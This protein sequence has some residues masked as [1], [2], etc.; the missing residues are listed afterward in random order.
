ME[1]TLM[2]GTEPVQVRKEK[3]VLDIFKCKDCR[4]RKVKVSN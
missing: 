2:T 3:R 4:R 1:Q